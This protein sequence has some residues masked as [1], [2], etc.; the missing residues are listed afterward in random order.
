MEH[1]KEFI[2]E[3]FDKEGNST[4]E[5]VSAIKDLRESIFELRMKAKRYGFPIDAYFRER[6][7][8]PYEFKHI[9]EKEK[10]YLISKLTD[11]KNDFY[12]PQTFI[13]Y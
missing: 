7:F 2:S 4:E 6:Y 10:S 9:G 12:N 13:V 1:N 3:F 8:N 5:L 11:I